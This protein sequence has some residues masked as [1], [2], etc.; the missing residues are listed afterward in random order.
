[1]PTFGARRFPENLM[2]V[3]PRGCGGEVVVEDAV[4]GVA[5]GDAREVR[6][7]RARN[8]DGAAQLEGHH[9]LV[10]LPLRKRDLDG[11][12]LHEERVVQNALEVLRAHEREDALVD[13]GEHPLR[14]NAAHAG[15][16]DVTDLLD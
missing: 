3:E 8:D 13:V 12:R 4:V 1:M 14:W 7:L 10:E 5:E 11:R 9:L 15:D 6:E 16:D 2:G